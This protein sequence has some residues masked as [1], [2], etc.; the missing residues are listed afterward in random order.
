M[1]VLAA[2][3]GPVPPHLGLATAAR[4]L[5][6][7]AGHTGNL[8]RVL[9]QLGIGLCPVRRVAVAGFTGCTAVVSASRDVDTLLIG[10]GRGIT[11][12]GNLMATGSVAGLTGEIQTIDIHVHIGRML[13]IV[14]RRVEMAVLHPVATPT[15]EMTGAAVASARLTDTLRHFH[16]VGR[17]PYLATLRWPHLR[18]VVGVPRIRRELLVGPSGVVAHQAVDIDLRGKV[19]LVILPAIADVTTGTARPVGRSGYAEIVDD[20]LLTQFLASQ[21]VVERPRPMRG[22]VQ[23]LGGFRMT[24]KAGLGHRR[25]ILERAPQLLEL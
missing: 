17:L 19:E 23:L 22:L 3:G 12:A 15:I 10:R 5:R 8:V 6:H 16:Q 25:A 7:M 11:A 4:E 13:G 14:H 2:R 24:S 21:R 1:L 9:I 20:V 18:L